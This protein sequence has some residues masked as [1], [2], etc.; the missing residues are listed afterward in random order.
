MKILETLKE[1]SRVL[2]IAKKPEWDD[3]AD[4]AKICLIGM[5]V[6]GL[7]GFVLYMIFIMVPL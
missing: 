2:K 7:I 3:F 6:L 5:A 4:T 1:Y